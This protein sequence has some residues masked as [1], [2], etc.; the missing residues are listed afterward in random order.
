MNGDVPPAQRALIDALATLHESS[1]LSPVA[2]RIM[3]VLL[4][5]REAELSSDELAEQAEAS[6]GTISTQTQ[7]LVERGLV[8]RFRKP[9]SRRTWYRLRPNAWLELL[10]RQAQSTAMVVGLA[11]AAIAEQADRGEVSAALREY[12]KLNRFF[13]ERI[14]ALIEAWHDY[15][16]GADD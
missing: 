1:G 7:F 8:D 13:A 10:E 14:P 9:G 6:K 16:D 3:G 2:G 4:I 12:R 11:D 5:S 15:R